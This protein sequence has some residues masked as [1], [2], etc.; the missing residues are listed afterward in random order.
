MQ[1]EDGKLLFSLFI[2]TFSSLFEV[3]FFRSR[4]LGCTSC[5]LRKVGAKNLYCLDQ[6]SKYPELQHEGKMK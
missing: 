5:Q 3:C 4:S 6:N 2:T 1:L